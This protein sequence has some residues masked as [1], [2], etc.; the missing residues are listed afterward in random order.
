MSNIIILYL[1]IVTISC[2]PTVVTATMLDLPASSVTPVNFKKHTNPIS[3]WTE[4]I[5]N[6]INDFQVLLTCWDNSFINWNYIP[7]LWFLNYLQFLNDPIHAGKIGMAFGGLDTACYLI[8]FLSGDSEGAFYRLWPVEGRLASSDCRF[9]VGRW[10]DPDHF[11]DW[12]NKPRM[13]GPMYLFSST[14]NH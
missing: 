14:S 2:C 13:Y 9:G 7:F 8:L 3:M 6:Q 5:Y 11:V 12:R 10:K 1:S 4:R